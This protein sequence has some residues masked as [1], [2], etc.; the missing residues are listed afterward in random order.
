MINLKFWW[1]Y[2]LWCLNQ[3]VIFSQCSL[4]ILHTSYYIKY[5]RPVTPFLL[6]VKNVT[7]FK[8]NAYTSVCVNHS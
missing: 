5:Y 6:R 2:K 8:Q 4:T 3:E 7:D 1:K